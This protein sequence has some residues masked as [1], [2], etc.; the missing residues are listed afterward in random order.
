VLTSTDKFID[1]E[2][3]KMT[4]VEKIYEKEKEDTINQAIN[5]TEKN[6]AFEF[7]KNMLLD[8]EDI[9]KIV[10]YTKLK[11]EDINKLKELLNL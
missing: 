4:K 3:S 5:K 11:E 8:G 9:K 6:A 1:E 7:A 2:Y 10:K